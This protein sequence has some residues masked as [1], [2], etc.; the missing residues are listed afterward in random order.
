MPFKKSSPAKT[1]ERVVRVTR[2]DGTVKEYRYPRNKNKSLTGN[3]IEAGSVGALIKEFTISPEWKRLA[4]STRAKHIIYLRDLEIISHQKAAEITRRDI[5]SL[6]NAIA[7]K[8]GNGAGMGFQR[9]ASLVFAW[10]VENEWIVHNPAQRIAAL[11]GGHLPPWTEAEAAMAMQKLP[12]H[13]RRAVVLARFTGQRRGDLCA[14]PWSAYDGATIRLVQQK[15]G[16]PLAVPVHPSLKTEL[17]AWR[18]DAQSTLILTNF[19][20]RPWRRPQRLSAQLAEALERLGMRD[21]INMHGL[22]KLAA[23]ALAEAGCTVHEIAA[24]TGH[25]TLSMVELYT[26]SRSG[27]RVRPFSD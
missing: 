21:G 22:R 24:I 4:A 19:D 8:R 16:T 11:P 23:A 13:L 1:G 26:R 20:G 10:A 12:E 9:A 15:T 18:R 27:W 6:R 17:D 5:K 2:R 3:Y 14:L 25:R 7:E